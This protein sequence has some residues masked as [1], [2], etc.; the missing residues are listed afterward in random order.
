MLKEAGEEFFKAVFARLVFLAVFRYHLVDCL[1]NGD[2][3][4]D[5]ARVLQFEQPLQ[6][7]ELG[8][9]PVHNLDVNA[10]LELGLYLIL[11][12]AQIE[13]PTNFKERG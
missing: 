6:L 3:W 9:S 12:V 1:F 13:A 2:R 7:H 4:D 8:V 5:A 11:V 10:T